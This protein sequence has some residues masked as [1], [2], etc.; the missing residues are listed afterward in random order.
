MGKHDMLKF[1]A[2][3]LITTMLPLSFAFAEST[4]GADYSNSSLQCI[5]IVQS[6]VMVHRNKQPV[7]V[8]VEIIGRDTPYKIV[9]KLVYDGAFQENMI[10]DKIAKVHTGQ[11]RTEIREYTDPETPFMSVNWMYAPSETTQFSFTPLQKGHYFVSAIVTDANGLMYWADTTLILSYDDED[12]ANSNSEYNTALRA[13]DETVKV[14]MKSREVAIAIHDW[15]IQ[16]MK[17][18]DRLGLEVIQ[19]SMQGVCAN[20]SYVYEFLCSLAGLKCRYFRS[21]T[22]GHAWDI[23]WIDGQWLHV[24]CTWD[25][26]GTVAGREYL[27]LTSEQMARDHRWTNY[28]DSML[29]PFPGYGE[30]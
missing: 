25:D 6:H 1:V 15:I 24:D 13:M 11:R 26:N 19:D 17:Y 10:S 23:V 29:A 14:G 22:M 18:G 7:N 27:L 3:I 30:H 21:A 9:Y 16:H 2:L 5:N 4:D 8:T 28:P 12:M 20:Y